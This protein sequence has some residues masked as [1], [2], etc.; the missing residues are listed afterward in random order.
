[1]TNLNQDKYRT[2]LIGLLILLKHSLLTYKK[3]PNMHNTNVLRRSL[4]LQIPDIMVTVT[5]IFVVYRIHLVLM[6]MTI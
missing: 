4:F 3:V 2:F 1:M 5:H 6:F